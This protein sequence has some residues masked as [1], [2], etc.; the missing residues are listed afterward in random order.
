MK[1]RLYFWHAQKEFDNNRVEYTSGTFS[2][3]GI[4]SDL[5]EEVKHVIAKFSDWPINSFIIVSISFLG[6]INETT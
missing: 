3:T 1:K 6:E 4:S 5:Y 2:T